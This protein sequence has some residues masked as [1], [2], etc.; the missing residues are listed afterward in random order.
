[1]TKA[2]LI[3]AVAALLVC[4]AAAIPEAK[5][6]SLIA[7]WAAAQPAED[8][9]VEWAPGEQ[10]CLK[11][12]DD[13]K[14]RAV[15][16]TAH[17]V[18]GD[19]RTPM[20]GHACESCHGASPEHNNAKVPKGEK[21]PPTTVVFKG[22][23]TSPVAARNKV[24]A[25]CH[26]GGTHMNWQ[27]SQHQ[28]NDVACTDCHTAHTDRDPVLAKKTEP[29]VCFTCH[30][31]QRAESFL[32][33]HHPMREGKVTCSDPEQRG[34]F[35]WEHLPVREDCSNCHQSH[36]ATQSSLLKMRSP[37]LCQTCHQSSRQSHEGLISGANQLPGGSG[38]NAT[39]VLTLG[40]GCENCHSKIHGSNAPS[41][42]MLTR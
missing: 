42:G 39:Y 15:M 36:G 29:E 23:F 27:G 2:S 4:L 37:F 18:K 24:C 8:K 40:R 16:A 35:L 6:Q 22:E 41:G 12:H 26:M 25:T 21:R 32:A 28:A 38:R 30:A 1:M 7:Q 19:K 20:A 33:S 34:P 11:C 10:T 31:Q 17:G 5:A 9:P 14:S 13:A 3:K